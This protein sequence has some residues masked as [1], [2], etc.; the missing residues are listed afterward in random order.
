MLSHPY[1]PALIFIH[2]YWENHSLTIQT[3]VG[4][5]MSLSL[6]LSLFFLICCLGLSWL[7]FQGAKHLLILWLQSLSTVILEP[8]K[9]KSVTVSIFFPPICHDVMG[10]AAMILL[11]GLQPTRLHCP[12]DSPGKNIGVGCR[13]LLQGIFLTQGSNLHLYVSCIVRQILYHQCHLGNPYHVV[14]QS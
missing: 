8:M 14:V 12:W 5:G 13:A 6:S 9:I 4:K 10:P 11:F 3:F 1:G 2:D 7:F